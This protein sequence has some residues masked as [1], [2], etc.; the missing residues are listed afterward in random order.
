[1]AADRPAPLA[2]YRL[3]LGPGFGFAEAGG[4]GGY[5]DRLG[6]T[7]V[8]L[9]PVLQAAPGSTHG[10]DVVDHSRASD[11]LGGEH[12][13]RAMVAALHEVGLGV[14][15]DVVPNHMAAAL[16]QNR[17]WWDV[18]ENGP[19]SFWGSFFDIDWDPP[20]STLRNRVLLPILGRRYGR[21]LEA[22]EVALAYD[23]G[24]FTIHYFDHVLPVAP[25]SLDRVLAD[26][27]RQTASPELGF[28]ADALGELP[29]AWVTDRASV[30]RR[31]RDKGVLLDRVAA[32]YRSDVGV[33]AAVDAAVDAVN[34]DPVLL[35][36]LLERQNYRLAFWR[37]ADQQLDYRRFFDIDTLVALRVEEADVL[38]ETHA[39][40]FEWVA[41]GLVDGLRI[42][43]IDGLAVPEGYLRTV[44]ERTG[45]AW[46]VVE[47]ILEAGEE[48][49]PSWPVAGTTGYDFLNVVGKLFVDPAGEQPLTAALATL[50][51]DE[52][53][54]EEV[55]RTGKELIVETSLVADLNRVGERALRLAE[56]TPGL[57]DVTRAEV[58]AALRALVVA[59]PVYRTYASGRPADQIDLAV[60]ERAAADARAPEV[61]DDVLGFLLDVLAGRSGQDEA[62]LDVA[63]R[64]EQLTG[65]VMAKGV[66]DTAFYRYFRLVVHNEVGSDLAEWATTP[67]EWHEHGARRAAAGDGSLLATSTHD[68]KRSEDVRARLVL[69]SEIPGRWADAARA[70]SAMAGRHRAHGYPDPGTEYLLFQTLVGAWP[71]STE[72]ALEY[73]RKATREAKV[74]TSWTD[75]DPTYDAAVEG[76]VRGVLA[77]PELTGA[78][79]AFVAGLV[80]P[81]RV[82][83]LA[84][85]LCKLTA[86]G[87]PDVYQGTELWDLS[88]VDPDN[89]RPVDYGARSTLLGEIEEGGVSAA[90][91]LARS[92]EGLPKLLLTAR[93]LHLRRARPECFAP[94]AG[95]QALDVDG[96][97]ATNAVACGRG[98]RGE[99]REVVAVVPRLVLGWAARTDGWAGTAVTLPPGRWLD[100]LTGAVHPGGAVPVAGL[101][102]GFPVALLERAPHG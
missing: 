93:A 61:D 68:T 17:W 81:G 32:L 78:V 98:R 74:H 1:M 21:V 87:V 26:A 86:P 59:F 27:A 66:E 73:A 22:R 94:G 90:D 19:S 7:H 31:H 92:D 10:Y 88:L 47:K 5:L 99:P 43:H 37:T 24:S 72:R 39:H 8:Y 76:W 75:P 50:T 20:E 63:R 42:D 54:P 29:L 41:S 77:D 14:V 52:S 101:L 9:S 23:E 15:L 34:K 44:E 48:L 62:R 2:T 46:V 96:P 60:L 45:G 12:G 83:S 51:G 67:E 13:F 89:R 33:G 65:P 18:L 6:I 82:V 58:H 100:V 57:R 91:A 30:R 4:L 80:E 36:G 40:V 28:L 16:P 102:A 84:Q 79:D 11:D 53:S 71:L 25:R 55:I 70:W 35:D 69:L 95:Y 56:Q 3:Q 97:A 49:P 38:E 64:F 85:T